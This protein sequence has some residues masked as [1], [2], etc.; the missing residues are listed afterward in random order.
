VP[1]EL[2]T[3]KPHVRFR[4]WSGPTLTAAAITLAGASTACTLVWTLPA[5][6]V[7][8]AIGVLATLAAAG[9]ALIAW[10]AA[11]QRASALTYWDIVGALTVVGVFA[12]LLSDPELALPLLENQRTE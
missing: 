6:L 8:P 5:P 1:I 9:M 11:Q 2:P 7:L 3:P 10:L 4:G 12:A